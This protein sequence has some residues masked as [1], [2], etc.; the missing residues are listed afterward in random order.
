M[1]IELFHI[2]VAKVA[3]ATSYVHHSAAISSTPPTSTNRKTPD[4]P[5]VVSAAWEVEVA[6][7]AGLVEGLFG[8][9]KSKK[10][11]R[12]IDFCWVFCV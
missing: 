9:L 5:F 6:F 4:W 7:K 1:K 10:Y 11:I 3:T 2:N 8:H 12:K